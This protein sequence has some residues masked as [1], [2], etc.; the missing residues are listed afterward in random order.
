MKSIFQL[1]ASLTCAL[2]L[3]AC[4]GGGSDSPAPTAPVQPAFSKTD[5]VVGTGIEAAAGD[6]VTVNYTGWLYSAT[7]AGNK[8]NQID[9]STGRGPLTFTLGSGAVIKGWDQGVPGM[10]V[11]G[12][13]TLVIPADLAYGAQGRGSI[14]GNAALIFD[15]EMVAIKR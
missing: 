4:G 10:K 11:G 8:G 6:S 3:T 1:V 7:A 9:T 13:R 2:A 12:K 15:V 5:T 14:P